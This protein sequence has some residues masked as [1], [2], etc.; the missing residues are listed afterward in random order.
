M[1]QSYGRSR[2]AFERT[3]EQSV[4][5]FGKLSLIFCREFVRNV[6]ELSRAKFPGC[7]HSS[8]RRGGKH[9]SK[10]ATALVATR[11]RVSI[12][13]DRLIIVKMTVALGTGFQ[14]WKQTCQT[15]QPDFEV[16][17]NLI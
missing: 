17:H 10:T 15:Q 11:S 1:R 14:L 9:C 5:E 3:H 4:R 7:N 6:C 16:T 8:A 2:S 13:V 12:Q